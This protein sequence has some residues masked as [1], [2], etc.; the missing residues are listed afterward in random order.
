MLRSSMILGVFLPCLIGQTQSDS[1]SK[2]VEAGPTKSLVLPEPYATPRTSNRPKPI[3]WPAGLAPKAPAGFEVTLFA[4]ELE[5]PRS[6]YV[7]PNG[8]VLAAECDR[9]DGRGVGPSANRI[10][11]D[12]LDWLEGPPELRP[13]RPLP[14]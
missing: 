6:L 3:G 13:G 14:P 5:N 1:G 4:D 9:T 7:L 8:D 10:S 11:T 12:P 2:V